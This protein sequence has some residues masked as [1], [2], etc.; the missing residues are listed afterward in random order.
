M[1]NAQMLR[2]RMKGEKARQARLEAR[3]IKQEQEHQAL[4]AA[5]R[6]R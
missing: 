6:D 5:T 1:H 2:K 3:A 4:L